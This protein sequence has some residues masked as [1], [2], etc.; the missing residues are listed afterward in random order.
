V[1]ATNTTVSRVG[2]EQYETSQESGGLSGLPVRDKSTWVIKTLHGCLGGKLPIIGVG[3]ISDAA[4][5]ADKIRAGASLVQIYTGFIYEGPALIAAAANGI[6]A[7][8][9]SPGA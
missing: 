7:Y 9:N 8:R 2:V 1:I 6:R 5:A 4:S 3:G